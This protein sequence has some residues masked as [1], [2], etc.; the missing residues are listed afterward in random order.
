[1]VMAFAVDETETIFRCS[2]SEKLSAF[3]GKRGYPVMKK[4]VC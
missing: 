2:Y 3:E 1:M 4:K